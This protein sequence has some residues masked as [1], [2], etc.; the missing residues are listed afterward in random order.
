MQTIEITYPKEAPAWALEL[1]SKLDRVL[2]VIRPE[3][4]VAISLPEAAALL[5]YSPKTLYGYAND[6]ASDFPLTVSKG[7]I[8]HRKYRKS[9][10]EAW[11]RKKGLI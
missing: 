11:G 2:Q 6:V 4:D 1:S 3:N 7:K 9:E 5:K 10:I 8:R